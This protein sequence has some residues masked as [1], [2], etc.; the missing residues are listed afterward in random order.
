MGFS[1]VCDNDINYRFIVNLQ[2][3]IVRLSKY[4]VKFRTYDDNF[5]VEVQFDPS[6]VIVNPEQENIAFATDDNTKGLCYYMCPITSDLSSLFDAVN[7]T[8]AYNEELQLKTEL[9]RNTIDEIQKLFVDKSYEE[10]LGYVYIQAKP[11][12]KQSKPR[13]TSTK[14][15][16]VKKTTGKPDISKEKRG[17]NSVSQIEKNIEENV[18]NENTVVCDMTKKEDVNVVDS[19]K[20]NGEKD[21]KCEDVVSIIDKKIMEAVKNKKKRNNR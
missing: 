8:I 7:R 6:W 17:K 20:A 18:T 10:L 9:F 5:V 1:G 4:G 2:D 21:M 16:T 15:E 14:K 12:S 19:G 11:E 13:K 3:I